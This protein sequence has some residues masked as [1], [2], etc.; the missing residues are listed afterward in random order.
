MTTLSAISAKAGYC[1][2]PT[3]SWKVINTEILVASLFVS[4]YLFVC[5]F[6]HIYVTS[7]PKLYVF[8]LVG[9][10]YNQ[11]RVP[12]YEIH[13]PRQ[14]CC[15]DDTEASTVAGVGSSTFS[16]GFAWASRSVISEANVDGYMKQ[17]TVYV[18]EKQHQQQKA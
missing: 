12:V 9:G 2:A 14:M 1:K 17:G 7:L 11:L 3:L 18:T 10:H 13:T 15:V 8:W 5:L 16:V 6:L 4:S